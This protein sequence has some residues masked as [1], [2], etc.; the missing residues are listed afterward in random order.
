MRIST[1]QCTHYTTTAFWCDGFTSYFK[2][3]IT[4]ILF[5]FFSSNLTAQFILDGN[6]IEWPG[7][8]NNAANR[9]KVFVR[10]ANNTNDNQF[11]T[12]S[13]D[14]NLIATWGWSLGQTNDKGD[15]SNA[16]AA[17]LPGK[18]LVFFGDRA[19][20]NGDAQIGFWFFKSNIHPIGTGLINSLF[21]V[22]HQVG[23]LLVLSNFTNGGGK[24]QL[25]VFKWVGGSNPLTLV[26]TLTDH[27][28]VNSAPVTIPATGPFLASEPRSATWTYQ[29]K[30]VPGEGDPA[31]NTYH[32]GAYFEGFIDLDD[33]PGASPCIQSFL[34]ET[35]NS[36]S[37][38]ASLQDFVQGAF[39]GIPPPPIVKGVEKCF[40]FDAT[41][42]AICSG[43]TTK[44]YDAL[45]GGNLVASGVD[46]ITKSAGTAAG[47]YNYYVSCAYGECES[48]RR[49]VSI[50]INPSPTVDGVVT[51]GEN[52][53]SIDDGITKLIDDVYQIRISKTRVAHLAATASGGSGS[54][55]SVVW[56]PLDA[57]AAI[58]F[59]P[60]GANATFTILTTQNMNLFGYHFKVV[61]TDSKGCVAEDIV[62]II[63]FGTPIRCEVNGPGIVC[64][65]STNSTN[66]YFD[67][68]LTLDPDFNYTWSISGN[69]TINNAPQVNVTSVT[70]TAGAAAGSYT[71]TLTI[72]GK[73]NSL[74]DP[75]P[76]PKTTTVTL[77]TLSLDKTDVTCYGG[78]NGTVTATFS[79]GTAPYK[80][81]INGG[82]YINSVTS[83]YT[84]PNLSA[85]E[86]TVHVADAN[87]CEAGNSITVTQPDALD[88]TLTPTGATC[89]GS[90]N[91]SISTVVTGTPLSDLE[92]KIDAGGFANVASS[93]VS[94]TGLAAGSHTITLHRKSD[95][96]CQV[97]KSATVSQPDALDITLTPTGATCFGSSNGSISAVVTGTP[98]SDL[99]IR[100]DDGGFANVASSPVIFTGLAAGSHTITLHRKSDNTCQVIKSATVTQPDALDI[101]L[102]PAGATCFGS[103][104]GSISAV[105]TG[106]PLS[107]LEI[108]IDAGGFANVA[109]SPVSFTGLAAGSHTIIL[110]RKSDN[111]CTVT[112]SAT[113]TQPD[114]LVLTLTPTGATCF[115]SYNGSIS[116]VVTGTP[117]SDLEIR[118]DAGVFANVVSSPVIFT[119]LAAGSHT[120]TLH[121]KSDKT[122]QVIKSATVTQPV[123]LVLTLTPTGATCFGSSNGSIS[124]VVTG[125]PLS[126]LE[127][128]IDAGG[129]ANVASS[130]VRFA[131]LAA[132]SHTITLHRKSDKTCQV[133]KSATVT[134][135]DALDLTLTPTGATCFGSSNGSISAVVK[136]TPLSDLEIRIDA[137]VFANVASSP[138]SFTG[139]AAGSHTITL[140]RKSDKTCQVIKS[141]TVTQPDAPD[142]TLT[143]TGA[144]CFGSSNGSISAVVT[145][146]PFSDLEIRIDA[147]GFANVGSSLVSFTGLAAGSHTITLHRK[148]DNTCQVI[149]SATVTQPDAL[150]LTLTPTGATCFGSSN[151]S[152][153]GVVTGTPLSDLEIRIG[154]GEF[155]SVASSPVIFTGLAAGSHTITLHRKSDNTCQVINSA[156]VTQPDALDLTLTP[157]DATCFGSS[158]GSISGVVTGTPLSDLEIRIDDGGFAN[159]ALSPVI[160]TGLA[161][162]SHTITLHRISDNTCSVTKSTTVT[163][164]DALDLTLTPTD[165]TCYGSSNGSISTVVTG[166]P[167]SD[168]EIRIDDGGFAN[169][170]SSPVIF[171]GLAAG[172]HTIILHRKSDNTCQVIKSATVTQPDALDL[173][174]T[175]TD[176]TCFGSSNGS[177]SA[178][179][180][181]TPL[182][183]LEIMNDDGG[184]A[185]V[186]SSP[187]IFTGLA[188]GSHT[189]TLHRKSDNTC[190]V[191]KSAT[192]TQ[193]DALDLTLT[194]TDATCYGS[195][196]GS[197]SAVVTGSPLSDLE[198]MNDDGG[199]ANVASSPVLFTGLAAGSHTITLHRKSDNTCQVIKSATVTQPD[200]LD[201]TLTP[202]DATC[203][204]SSNGSISAVVTGTPLSD[205]EI[206]NDDGGFANVASSPVIFTGLAAGS[207]TIILHRKSDNTCTVTKSAIVT[208]PDALDLI[209]TPTGATCFGSSNGSISAV[210]T[211][212]PL[213]DLEIRID[214]GGFANVASSPVIFTGLAAGS[215]TIILHRKSDN[216]CSVTKSATV[217][218]PDALDLTL[219]PTNT[220]CF[221][222]NKLISAAITGTP[223]SDLEIKIDGGAFANVTASPVTFS[224][225]IAGSHTIIIHRK[226]DNTC[227]VTKSATVTQPPALALSL[228]KV[229]ETC[230]GNDGSVSATFSGG[231]GS[232]EARIDAGAFA[233]ATSPKTFTG[234]TNGSHTVNVRDANDNSC[235]ISM[236][237]TVGWAYACAHLFPTQTTCCNYLGG[238]TSLFLQKYLCYSVSGGTVQQNVNPGVFFYYGDFTLASNVIGT[239]VIRVHQEKN[240]TKL[241]LFAPTNDNNL[242]VT[243]GNCNTLTT[244]V[245]TVISGGDVTFT[246]TN[247]IAGK[248]VVSVKYDSKSVVGTDGSGSPTVTYTFSMLKGGVL[249]LNSNGQMD[250]RADANCSS[251]TPA[252]GGICP[253]TITPIARITPSVTV[254]QTSELQAGAYPN[255]FNNEVN[256]QIV[257]PQS[258]KALLEAWDMIGRKL[259]I[260]YD[261]N[262]EAGVQKTITY[263]VPVLN[264]V[265]MIYRLTFGKH[266]V[267]GTLLPGDRIYKP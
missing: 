103:S 13:Q 259:A 171:S 63:P 146:T 89:F 261:G 75:P 188:A 258:G 1:K 266:S 114:A 239:V 24:V 243:I 237:V 35:R 201:L 77:V 167:L 48:A 250:A 176:A 15:I 265:P 219:T 154:E 30:N 120:I 140:H 197:I 178:V 14:P 203:Y 56:T 232:Y 149:K 135:P 123:A 208:Q 221:G 185:N 64:A 159:V 254:A 99:E 234:L 252:P 31:P 142:L 148:S 150:D 96:I 192:V 235:T 191:I 62:T 213:S 247:P 34:L 246:L 152:I 45:T 18:M 262:I 244:P 161:A 256:F 233:A 248:Y 74:Q 217:T 22:E 183:D 153:S 245:S 60:N 92:I 83:P 95:N 223:L 229:D 116:A 80:I 28:I 126:D 124:A 3:F 212:T 88:L 164:P 97:I 106:T 118:I 230:T 111:T 137:G 158:N 107:D 181:G 263:K 131:G 90:T 2:K 23:D 132:G 241:A 105:V 7:I 174:L 147:G 225:L 255:P 145:G 249:V 173:T 16:G 127:I 5:G 200:A 79:G 46:H 155:T 11:T 214:D 117:L 76:C 49:A 166:T 108:R 53:N 119:G 162:G 36:Q 81:Q 215:H 141:A 41:A 52:D 242:R 50:K 42:T 70:V 104:N 40:G 257:S 17:L 207:H 61:L 209:L 157:T 260:I 144:S 136:G 196:N 199:F 29:G 182:S 165:A 12:G 134:Q 8:L 186:A 187:V 32:T 236:P 78:S 72:T 39:N 210:V 98:L 54:Y 101:T 172:S 69:G 128:R 251:V 19:A 55:T 84:F 238:N 73:N 91:G 253:G 139:L 6:P 100:I 180:T 115:G 66:T 169:V 21:T 82:S 231:S 194:P 179:V 44:W 86:Y 205:L 33:I 204:G 57:N 67:G 121:R 27:A 202:T 190:Q 68:N 195:S 163:Q 113:V 102:T 206:M 216:T 93:P 129:F 10:D 112:K 87:N 51:E 156:T 184:F 94:F 133:I 267:H 65:G 177:I 110:H 240:S 43:T 160:F 122:C 20:I 226:S 189:I 211:G 227:S 109:S 37:T 264:R 71:V 222:G 85:G 218:Q 38:T 59:V 58:S 228:S 193:P 168:M 125:T 175:P 224:G 220:T 9:T 130:P 143:P 4:L 25:R 26:Q 47:T 170:A 151:G 198:I 138:V